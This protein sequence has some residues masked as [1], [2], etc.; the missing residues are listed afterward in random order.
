[1][2]VSSHKM[3]SSV[4]LFC[5]IVE[6]GELDDTFCFKFF[7]CFQRWSYVLALLPR[8]EQYADSHHSFITQNLP[9]PHA[10]E[11]HIWSAVAG[12]SYLKRTK[13]NKKSDDDKQTNDTSHSKRNK[14]RLFQ[15]LARP[16]RYGRQIHPQSQGENGR[17]ELKTSTSPSNTSFLAHI[18]TT[19]PENT[20][21]TCSL[22][23]VDGPGN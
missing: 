17:W 9:H 21:C 7:A 18:A 2:F 5:S 22:H 14:R 16:Q 15:S 23:D 1:M 20:H 11:K 12:K 13:Q 6:F 19:P 10:V 3:L 4:S 8:G